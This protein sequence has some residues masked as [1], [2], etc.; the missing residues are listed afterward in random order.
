MVWVHWGEVR[1]M[2][3]Q[4]SVCHSHCHIRLYI[5]HHH[6]DVLDYQVATPTTNP[7][8]DQRILEDYFRLDVDLTSLYTR[9]G[10]CHPMTI[11]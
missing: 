7:A 6:G 9:C 3:K 1:D 5:L 11:T 10:I 4:W 8:E 2:E